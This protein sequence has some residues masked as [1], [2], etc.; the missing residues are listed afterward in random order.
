MRDRPV[1]R[2]VLTREKNVRASSIFFFSTEIVMYF[3]WIKLLLSAA[4][5]SSKSL[6]SPRYWSCPS[7]FM[8]ISSVRPKFFWLSCLLNSVI[9]AVAPMGSELR[10]EQFPLLLR[11]CHGIIHIKKAPS[12]RKLAAH[13]KYTV[14]VNALNGNRFLYTARNGKGIP[15]RTAPM[16]EKDQCFF[17]SRFIASS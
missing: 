13:L 6:Y 8:G 9:F 14:F 5:S 12:L 17:T 1:V 16:L 11:G 7:P 10:K 3:S 2:S 15:L 4:L